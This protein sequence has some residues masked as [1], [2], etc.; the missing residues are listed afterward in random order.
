MQHW[1]KSQGLTYDN[2]PLSLELCDR[3]QLT[4]LL[5]G[6]GGT[7][8]LGIT[9]STMHRLNGQEVRAEINGIA[10]LRG[11]PSTLFQGVLVHELGHVWLIMHGIK[12]LP[13]WAEEG[14]CELLSHRYYSELATAQAGYHAKG[15]EQSSD[16]AYGEGFRR[17]RLLADSVGFQ[18]LVETLSTSK[19]LPTST[20]S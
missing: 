10:V 17:V 9:L 6:R 5:K 1:V 15:I 14:F 4:N 8:T 12:D 3:S 19:R 2:I 11:M 7:D 20:T 16:P 13:S 18:R